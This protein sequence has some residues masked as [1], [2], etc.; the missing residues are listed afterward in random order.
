M[1]IC[2]RCN[3]E[4]NTNHFLFECTKYT[5]DSELLWEEVRSM[6][7]KY[8]ERNEMGARELSECANL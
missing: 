7:V 2:E 6:V 5:H 4:I 3:V 1:K 8:M